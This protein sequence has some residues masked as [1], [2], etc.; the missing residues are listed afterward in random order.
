MS[1]FILIQKQLF[2]ALA[3]NAPD[4]NMLLRVLIKRY[5]P[6]PLRDY[7]AIVRLI[8]ATKTAKGLSVTCRLDHGKY[9]TGRRVT[10]EQMK[11]VRIEPME[12]HGEWNYIIHSETSGKT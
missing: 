2:K 6:E 7:E 4:V 9:P 3:Q 8:G 1:D 11:S 12:F 10:N 5:D